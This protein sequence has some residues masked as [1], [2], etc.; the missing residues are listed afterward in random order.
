MPLN[1]TKN[2]SNKMKARLYAEEVRL[3]ADNGGCL[4]INLGLEGQGRQF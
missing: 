3:Y 4:T 2:K 1:Q